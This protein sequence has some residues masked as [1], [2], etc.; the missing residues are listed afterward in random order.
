MVDSTIARLT[1]QTGDVAKPTQPKGDDLLGTRRGGVCHRM[2]DA[3]SI[4]R[5]RQ[6]AVLN[7]SEA[8]VYPDGIAHRDGSPSIEL[9]LESES[10]PPRRSTIGF[11]LVHR[12]GSG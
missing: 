9:N 7:D 3:L 2:R 12:Q 11:A 5:L 1:C 6:H 4:S 10:G 8:D